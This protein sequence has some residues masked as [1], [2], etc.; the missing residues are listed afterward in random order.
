MAVYRVSESPS[1]PSHSLQPSLHRFLWFFPMMSD[2]F[3]LLS[4]LRI[5]TLALV[6]SSLTFF[7]FCFFF[8]GIVFTPVLLSGAQIFPALLSE[9]FYRKNIPPLFFNTFSAL[10]LFLFG[11]EYFISS[12]ISVLVSRF[13]F[14]FSNTRGLSF[15]LSIYI[16]HFT[17]VSFSSSNSLCFLGNKTKRLY[18]FNSFLFLFFFLSHHFQV[19]GGAPSS[20]LRE[21]TPRRS[22]FLIGSFFNMVS[23]FFFFFLEV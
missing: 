2:C 4:R 6:A 5:T 22:R 7:C 11:G 8:F 14:A 16:I 23:G 17:F 21:R 10:L 20:S 9:M 15:L 12:I 19:W 18:F 13:G 1:C 3:S